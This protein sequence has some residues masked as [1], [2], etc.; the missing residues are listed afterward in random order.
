MQPSCIPTQYRI[1]DRAS[2]KWIALFSMLI[3]HTALVVLYYGILCGSS[4]FATT[5]SI[6]LY[7]LYRLMRAIGRIA[8]PLYLFMLV[9]GFMHTHDRKAYGRNLLIFALLSEIPFNL[10]VGQSLISASY[11]NVMWTLLFG[12]IMMCALE[13]IDQSIPSPALRPLLYLLT[14][15]IIAWIAFTFK[16]DYSYKGILAL[17][18]MYI[19]R[20]NRNMTILATAIAFY[21]E[22][23]ALL[24][25]IPLA[26]YNDQKGTSP[27]NLFYWFYPL[28]LL[29]LYALEQ[30]LL[31]L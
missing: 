30:L 6:Q 26:L 8:F 29:A 13:K 23:A 21:W 18:L 27:K 22:P 5:Y 7:T 16:T 10:T 12:F 15:A 28:H 4:T 11:Q 1:L 9:Q 25:A 31:H 24:A 3:D 2:L 17:A 19:F 14:I 20:Y